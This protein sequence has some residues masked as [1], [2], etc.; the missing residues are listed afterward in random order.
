[1]PVFEQDGQLSVLGVGRCGLV[2]IGSVFTLLAACRQQLFGILERILQ[3]LDSHCI[4]GEFSIDEVLFHS[5]M[6]S[7]PKILGDAFDDTCEVFVAG[8]G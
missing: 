4:V 7:L 5:C 8:V 3:D 6:A 2:L 1:M